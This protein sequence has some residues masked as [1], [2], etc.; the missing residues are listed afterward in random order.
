[1]TM[2]T[3]PSAGGANATTLRWTWKA[4]AIGR[5]MLLATHM[6]CSD[7]STT[8]LR[9]LQRWMWPMWPRRCYHK[10]RL[11]PLWVGAAPPPRPPPGAPAHRLLR[12]A[13]LRRLLL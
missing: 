8:R 12:R 10:P 4:T 13:G 9:I 2:S 11:K 6:I 1:M 3:M 7:A 5:R